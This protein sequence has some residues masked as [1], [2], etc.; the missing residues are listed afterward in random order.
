MVLGQC[1]RPDGTEMPFF[2]FER[3]PTFPG[4]ERALMQYLGENMKYPAKARRRGVQ[5]SVVVTFVIEKNGDVSN[6][7]AVKKI[8]TGCDEEAERVI[9]E[10]PRWTPGYQDE[11]PVKVRFSLPLHFRLE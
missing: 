7:E 3:A 5:G 11:Y 10:M 2:A 8:G 4:G 9:R 6:V 1:L